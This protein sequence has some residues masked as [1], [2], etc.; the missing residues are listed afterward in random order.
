M[1]SFDDE[2]DPWPRLPLL[3]G[4]GVFP[5]A[6]RPGAVPLFSVEGAGA[7][8]P[9]AALFSAGRG[10]TMEMDSL[11]TW[12]WALGESGQGRGP[13]TYARFWT[14]TLNWLTGGEDFRRVRLEAPAE[15][16]TLGDDALVRV[17]VR[18]EARKPLSDAEVL[19]E[20]RGP[21]GTSSSARMS[22][23][24]DGAFAATASPPRRP[25][26]SF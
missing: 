1:T 3:E 14:R 17:Y 19:L 21:D 15:R 13:A 11:T 10:R 18:D 6:L 7:P 20:V 24:G 9:W 23:S 5:G 25:G 8:L 16:L 26:N 12:R 22:P 2:E 4:P